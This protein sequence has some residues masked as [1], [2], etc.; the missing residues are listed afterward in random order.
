MKKAKKKGDA[1]FPI[2][3]QVEVPRGGFT[4]RVVGSIRISAWN[5]CGLAS[6]AKNGGFT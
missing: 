2:N 3:L 5:V 6:A 1:D 4:K